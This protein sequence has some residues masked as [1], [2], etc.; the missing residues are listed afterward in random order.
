MTKAFAA[1]TDAKS[2]KCLIWDLD[3]TL[4][5]G[6]LS[7]GDDVRLKHG[8]VDVLRTLD[9]R[10]I[11]HSI[12]SKNDYD[13]A[14]AK[15]REFGLDEYFLYP[16]IN[17]AAKS[18]S[19]GQIAKDL[20]LGLNTFG[21]IDDQPFERAEVL[22]VHPQVTTYDAA[23]LASVL[24]YPE[25]IPRFITDDSARR[26]TAYRAE[27]ARKTAREE[28]ER[29][30]K[31]FLDSL[32]MVFTIAPA[33]EQDLRRCE[34]LTVRTNQL[35]TTGVTY[36]YDELLELSRSPDHMLLL[37]SLEDRFGSYGKIGIVL[38]D[39]GEEVWTIQLLLMSCRVISRGV[40]G[41]LLTHV[42]RKAAN[43]GVKLEALFAR[44]D[45]NRLMQITYQL[46]GFR[47]V[48][49]GTPAILEYQGPANP[50]MPHGVEIRILLTP[51]SHEIE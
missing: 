26:R 7:E 42:I 39:L 27:L 2:L 40:G 9:E 43:A 37:A 47:K 48:G 6:T 51:T 11:L 41:I 44:N 8:V 31:E 19:V 13:Q 24:S 46:A 15:T 23:E 4:W 28:S 49:R 35:N 50:P 18:V 22:F 33:E 38:V 20:N 3:N 25:M 21:F 17:W 30:E 16:Q 29:P 32:N 14:W 12:A 34:E 5:D 1:R 36:S 45:R 10:G